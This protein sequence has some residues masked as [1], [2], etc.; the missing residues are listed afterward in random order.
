MF[1]ARLPSAPAFEAWVQV[2]RSPLR[3]LLTRVLT[4]HLEKRMT[5]DDYTDCVLAEDLVRIDP[6]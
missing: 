4:D 2:E 3:F 1:G 5:A 6:T